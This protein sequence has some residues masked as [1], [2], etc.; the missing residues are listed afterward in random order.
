MPMIYGWGNGWGWSIIMFLAMI[1]PLAILGLLIYYAVLTGTRNA[2]RKTD[3]SPME[4]L[5]TRYA[6]G[7]LESQE[8]H[9]LQEELKQD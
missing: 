2:A 5:K 4:I 9:R 3:L 6:K 1:I 7:E 8:Y